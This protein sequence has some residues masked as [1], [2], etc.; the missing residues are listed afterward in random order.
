MRITAA[1]KSPPQKAEKSKDADAH[2][3]YRIGTLYHVRMAEPEAGK[4][5]P[6][7]WV[8]QRSAWDCR[9]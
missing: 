7:R 8:Q 9:L 1:G 3:T 2:A 4:G 6:R 5:G